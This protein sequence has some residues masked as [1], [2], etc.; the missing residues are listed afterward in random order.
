MKL[1]KPLFDVPPTQGK[2]KAKKKRKK[3]RGIGVDS[4]L[5]GEFSHESRDD[6]GVD[7]ERAERPATE[8][9]PF[10]AVWELARQAAMPGAI[11][12]SNVEGVREQCERLGIEARYAGEERDEEEADLDLAT[13]DGHQK[14]E[15]RSSC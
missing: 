10:D 1:P 6:D 7:V 12:S 9:E 8:D 14:G 13:L 15:E 5:S 3:S 4:T 11:V 2:D